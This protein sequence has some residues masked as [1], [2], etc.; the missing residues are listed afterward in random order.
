M[1]RAARLPL[2]RPLVVPRAGQVAGPLLEQAVQGVLDGPSDELAQVG[3][4]GLLVQCYDG[5]G[6]GLPPV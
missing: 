1:P 6:H 4:Q 2:G 5:L 3:L